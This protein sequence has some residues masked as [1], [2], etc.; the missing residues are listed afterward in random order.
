MEMETQG[1]RLYRIG[2]GLVLVAVLLMYGL[3]R[4]PWT[5]VLWVSTGIT[6]GVLMSK[7]FNA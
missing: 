4:N 6:G 7:Y 2:T 5:T 3:P 1:K